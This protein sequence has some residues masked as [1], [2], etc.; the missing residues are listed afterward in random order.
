M[1]VG[2]L[3][4]D[5]KVNY[6]EMNLSEDEVNSAKLFHTLIFRQIVPVIKSFMIFDNYNLDNCFLIVPGNATSIVH[7]IIL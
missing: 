6:A 1:N 2:E 5:V 4:V 7:V 3:N